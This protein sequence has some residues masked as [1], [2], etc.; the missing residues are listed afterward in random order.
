MEQSEVGV[1]YYIVDGGNNLCSELVVGTGERL[2][3]GTV[4]K[5]GVYR[6]LASVSDECSATM[7]GEVA[8]VKLPLPLLNINHYYSYPEGGSPEGVQ[9]T[10]EPETSPGVQ[11][12]LIDKN[13]PEDESWLDWPTADGGR[14]TY[15]MWLKEGKYEIRTLSNTGGFECEA[16]DSLVIEKIKLTP[17]KLEVIGNPYKCVSTECR[18]LR[19][20]GSE[21]GTS[22]SLF[23]VKGADTTFI[24]L[25]EGT[26]KPISW[27]N[28]C[29]TGYFFVKAEKILSDG[30]ICRSQMGDAVHLY[31]STTIEKFRL[32]GAIT[33]YCND[34]EPNGKVILDSSQNSNITYK[35]YCNGREMPGKS[36]KGAGGNKLSWSGLEGLECVENNDVGNVYTVVATDEHCEVEMAGSVNIVMTNPVSLRNYPRSL[37]A[38]TGDKVGIAM[39]AFGCLLSYEWTHDGRVVGNE[40]GYNID[41]VGIDDMGVYYCKVSNYCGSVT[42]EAIELGVREVVTMPDGYMADELVCSDMQ[43]VKLVGKGVGGN[44][45]WYKAGTTDTISRERILELKDATPEDAGEY[46]CYTWNQCGGIA[47]TVLLEFNRVPLVTDYTYHVDTV[48]VNSVYDIQVKSR[49][50]VVWYRNDVEITG[51]HD[52]RYRIGDVTLGDEGLYKIKAVNLCSEQ[53]Y[54]IVKLLV[55]DS[56]RIQSAPPA[57]AHYCQSTDIRLEVVATPKERVEYTWWKRLTKVVSGQNFYTFP[58][59]ITK[60]NGAVYTV[61]YKNKMF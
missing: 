46:I 35:L 33:G 25:N 44:Y 13:V 26:G 47:D 5:P 6:V 54:N 37:L 38:C 59:N 22:Y 15:D 2:K 11:Y 55:D 50:S 31:V 9:V 42:S 14:I 53:T 21:K 16:V 61:N 56:I 8:I 51:K 3:V 28:Q 12:A 48:C 49:D 52:L 57:S 24:A 30:Q 58:A 43:D 10:V 27:G 36:L 32:L 4:Y 20:T 17:F 45:S 23:Q 39:D 34:S 19:L 7:N 1:T 18:P 41:S 29:D 40:A 60:E